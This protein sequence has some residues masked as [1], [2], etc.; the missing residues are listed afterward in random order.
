[1]TRFGSR[2]G[3]LLFAVALVVGLIA[4]VRW[5]ITINRLANDLDRVGQ[6]GKAELLR[7]QFRT[8]LLGGGGTVLFTAVFWAAILHDLRACD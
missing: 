2:V 5:A 1:M 4:L 8:A 3:V 7:I 6:H